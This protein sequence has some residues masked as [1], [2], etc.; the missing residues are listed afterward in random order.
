[1]GDPGDARQDQRG[2]GERRAGRN[3][4]ARDQPDGERDAQGEDEEEPPAL[5][6]E[7]I[8]CSTFVVARGAPG[9][10]LTAVAIA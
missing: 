5:P 10:R 8:W 3:G 9:R 6:V 7:A 1:M 2:E 4:A